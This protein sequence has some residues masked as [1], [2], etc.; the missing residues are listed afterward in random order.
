[1]SLRAVA[2]RPVLILVAFGLVALA[3]ACRDRSETGAPSAVPSA[4]ASP[5]AS[6]APVATG[7]SHA[8]LDHNGLKRTY[9]LF[10]PP[11]AAA[12][13]PGSLPLVVALHGGLGTGDQFAETSA[14]EEV[15]KREGFVVIF[16]D[17]VDRTWNG[18]RCCGQAVAKRVDDTGFL[19]R[20]IESLSGSLPIDRTRVFVTG[21]SNGA[22]MAFRFGC[23][24]ADLV[25]AIAPVAGSVEIAACRPSRGVSLLAI[26][27]D[28]DQNHPIGGGNG[29]RSVAGVPFTS[30]D[31]SL[32]AWTRAMGCSAD[33][34]QTASGALTTTDW[35]GC[36]DGA[37]ARYIVVA[38]AD[39]PWPGS[40]DRRASQLQG[41]PSQA[42]NATEVVWAFFRDTPKR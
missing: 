8:S 29:P 9:R 24:R 13:K 7:T 16:P 28:A 17:G 15:A 32:R 23:E 31:D 42:L 6:A 4:L 27:G 26:H 37:A 34:A 38:G 20:L 14:F 10:V 1:M 41:I 30:M 11:Q 19:A 35:K 2:V 33:P 25:T 5:A 3:A 22:I 40:A 12:A 39:H 18:G 36:R 21:H